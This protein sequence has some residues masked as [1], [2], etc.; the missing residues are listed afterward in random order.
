VL[1]DSAQAERQPQA[2]RLGLAVRGTFSPA[3]AWHPA[4]VA[5]LARTLEIT[6]TVGLHQSFRFKVGD[7]IETQAFLFGLSGIAKVEVKPTGLLVFSE[8]PGKAPFAF[9]VG[10]EHGLFVTSKSGDY[11]GF[12]EMFVEA[13]T[14]EFG[15]VEIEDT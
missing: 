13:M 1:P 11:F 3:R 5:R 14:G 12:L 6:A 9:D 2:T 10:I 8:L 15:A 7:G 4:V